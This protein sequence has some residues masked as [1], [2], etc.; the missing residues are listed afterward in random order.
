MIIHGKNRF[1]WSI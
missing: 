1:Y